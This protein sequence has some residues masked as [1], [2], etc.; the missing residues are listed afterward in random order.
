M[1]N[2]LLWVFLHAD[3]SHSIM[4]NAPFLVGI[5][6]SILHVVSGP[7]HLAA[8]TPLAI[9]NKLKAWLVG[10]GWGIGHTMGMLLIGILFIFFKNLIPIE[11]I[12]SYSELMVG[13][14][15]IAIGL[16]ALW[17]IFG[18][19]HNH[20]H[21]HPHSHISNDGES[22]THIH[23]HD[24][25][26]VNVHEHNHEL[27][28]RQSVISAIIIGTFHGLAG[29]SHLIGI[30]PTL[31]FPTISSSVFYLVGFGFGTIAAMIVFSTLLGFISFKSREKSKPFLFKS[32]QVTGALASLLVGFYWI[33]MYF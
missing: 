28:I 7:D 15:L 20:L 22:Y 1:T 31:A 27:P 30:L 26:G 19:K 17:R 2:S 21:D 5:L 18:K 32:I 24:H 33:A 10:L 16:W 25:K 8:V 9:D 14:I 23:S 12:S 3:H 13:F 4:L 6:A 29:V 11:A